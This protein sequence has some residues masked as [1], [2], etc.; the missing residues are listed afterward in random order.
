MTGLFIYRTILKWLQKQLNCVWQKNIERKRENRIK[1]KCLEM[2]WNWTVYR[3]PGHGTLH[4][5]LKFKWKTGLT[6]Y[7]KWRISVSS[8]DQKYLGPPGPTFIWQ[9]YRTALGILGLHDFV[10]NVDREGLTVL[11]PILPCKWWWD[12]ACAYDAGS[13]VTTQTSVF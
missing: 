13:F 8:I 9:L 1:I 7:T 2:L 6:Q 5:K 10:F 11:S 12:D 3:K 4:M